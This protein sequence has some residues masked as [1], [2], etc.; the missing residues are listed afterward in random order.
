MY[1][2]GRNIATVIAILVWAVVKVHSL[3]RLPDPGFS[4]DG[5]RKRRLECHKPTSTLCC[6]WMTYGEF[7]ELANWQ[8]VPAESHGAD[9]IWSRV[10]RNGKLPEGANSVL[11]YTTRCHDT[12]GTDRPD[13]SPLILPNEITVRCRKGTVV[14]LVN[15]PLAFPFLDR[16]GTLVTHSRQGE[17]EENEVE[18]KQRREHA[19]VYG[20]RWYTKKKL[21]RQAQLAREHEEAA[22]AAQ[23]EVDAQFGPQATAVP[24]VVASQV[25]ELP[26]ARPMCYDLQQP[27]VDQIQLNDEEVLGTMRMLADVF[28]AIDDN[29][30]TNRRF[31]PPLP[32]LNYD[33]PPEWGGKGP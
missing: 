9:E 24:R 26:A 30:N 20:E 4:A 6:K 14:K 16:L 11:S 27:Y 25:E 13:D 15:R 10:A 28:R 29:Q 22:R 17:C 32:D 1:W 31:V 8:D 2:L 21:A 23:A 18:R 5:S 12:R 19:K 3:K 33:P 7:H